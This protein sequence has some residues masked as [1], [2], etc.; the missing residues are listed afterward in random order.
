MRKINPIALS[1]IGGVFIFTITYIIFWVL[2]VCLDSPSATQAA[3]NTL[4]SYFGGIATLWAACVAAYLFNDWRDQHNKNLEKDISM[5]LIYIY[6]NLNSIGTDFLLKVED[7]IQIEEN[8]GSSFQLDLSLLNDMK[9]LSFE[10]SK[11]SKQYKMYCA[12]V[13]K[14]H[15][16]LI[17]DYIIPIRKSFLAID[18]T[19]E[20]NTKFSYMKNHLKHDIL[21]F[22]QYCDQ[23]LLSNIIKELRFDD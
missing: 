8:Q 21:E 13:K 11:F 23:E 2:F 22:H 12:A 10:L 6:L 9:N 18:R 19:N 20:N 16:A 17:T 15:K 1:V 5:D 7:N 14:D 3:I 4:G